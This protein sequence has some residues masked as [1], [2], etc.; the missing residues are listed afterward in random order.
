M[1]M[2]FPRI[3]KHVLITVLKPPSSGMADASFHSPRKG[4]LSLWPG[5]TQVHQPP[6]EE[7]TTARVCDHCR[8][9]LEPDQPSFQC[10]ACFQQHCSSCCLQTHAN[11]PLH[12]L[13]KSVTVNGTTWVNISLADVGFV[14]QLGHS[15]APCPLSTTETHSIR[16]LDVDGIQTV[17][18]R[19]CGCTNRS[20][21]DQLMDIGWRP[22]D[23]D[24]NDAAPACATSG[25]LELLHDLKLA[26]N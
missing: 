10:Y 21:L 11:K 25:F 3:D 2:L 17:C 16:V 7:G 15:G 19:L 12:F 18:Y 13:K 4:P 5:D 8:T 23:A 26:S 24:G 9:R 14:F 20:S 1:S 22:L 6:L